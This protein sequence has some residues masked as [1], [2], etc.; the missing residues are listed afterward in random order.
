MKV[1][2]TEIGQERTKVVIIDDFVANPHAVIEQ[3]AAL[4]PFPQIADNYYPGVRRMLRQGEAAYHYV[5]S[6]CGVLPPVLQRVYGVM[7]FHVREASFSMVTQRPET[8]QLIQRVP[9]FDTLNPADFAVLHYLSPTPF[10]GTGFYRHRRTGFERVS[11]ARYQLYLDALDEDLRAYGPPEARYITGSSPAFERLG[12]SE[13]RFN[14][15]IIYPGALLHCADIDPS[16]T[17]ASDPRTGRLTGNIFI[18]AETVT[19]V[20]QA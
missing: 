5:R 19:D 8:T 2:V 4:A 6:V 12:G 15:L 7:R 18:R 17:F 14:R 13:G 16:F 20:S 11:Q 10:G 9:H 3:A 1:L